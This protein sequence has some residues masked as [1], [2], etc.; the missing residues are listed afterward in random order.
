MA[1]PQLGTL[2]LEWWNEAD[3]AS[4]RSIKSR[5][6]IPN[7][8]TLNLKYW[9]VNPYMDRATNEQTYI[10]SPSGGTQFPYSGALN[11]KYWMANPKLGTLN[12]AM[13]WTALRAAR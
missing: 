9:M 12:G 11:L 2:N 1:S 8:M 10:L 4:R 6:S 13:R 5:F 7:W 3:G